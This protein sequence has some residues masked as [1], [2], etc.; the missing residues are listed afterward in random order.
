MKTRALLLA[1]AALLAGTVSCKG[2]IGPAG[3]SAPSGGPDPSTGTGGSGA[4]GMPVAGADAG[5][6]DTPPATPPVPFEA[7][8]PATVVAKVKGLL[9]GLPPTAAE[10]ASVTADSTALRGL[11]D[12]WMATPQFQ[13]KTLA[14]FKNAFQ[15][16]QV[17]STALLDQLGGRGIASNGATLQR[18]LVNIQESFPRTAWSLVASGKPFNG[19]ITTNQYMVTTA[20]ASFL[21][22][23]DDR[24]VDDKAATKSH[25][26]TAVPKLTVTAASDVT[27]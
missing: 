7:A 21:A 15:Q 18:L 14:F 27:T 4:P 24:Y 2:T 5:T 19:T 17:D 3:S 26:V 20:L 13:T 22:F 10:L 12:T 8:G 1:G 16:A 25:W 23:L 9:T 11:V 6:T